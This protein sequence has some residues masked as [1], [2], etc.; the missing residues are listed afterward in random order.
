MRIIVISVILAASAALTGFSVLAYDL[1]TPG[2]DTVPLVIC[3][4]GLWLLFALAVLLLRGVRG[5]AV[6]VLILAGSAVIGAAAM[7]GP[8]NTSTDSARYAWDGVVA[9]AGVSPYAYTP[10][11][12]RLDPLRPGWL[13]PA[14][15][16]TDAGTPVCVGERIQTAHKTPSGD[17]LCS[18]LNRT[19]VPTIYP[20]AAEIYFA[21]VRALTGPDA[22]Y[23]PL[24]LTGLLLSVGTTGMLLAGMRRRG[25][26][27]RHAALWAWCPLVAT[28]AIT[29][30]HVDMLG[31][32]FT[33]A[34]AF[35]VSTRR[36]WGGGIALGAAIATK[37]IPVLA[38][39]AMLRRQGWKVTVAAM[40]TFLLLY[41]PYVLTT[42]IGVLG[43][44]PGYLSEEGYEDGTRFALISLVA[45][46]GSAIIVAGAVL[47]VIA[48]LV[49][50]KTDPDRPWLGQ[51]VMIGSALLILSPRYSWYAL[52]LVPFIALSGRWEW[53]AVPL[54]LTLRLLVPSLPVT[55]VA[56]AAAVVLIVAITMYR[57][58]PVVFQRRIRP[59]TRPPRPVA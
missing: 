26:D 55:R 57:A 37:L 40:L 39:P 47:A 46:G 43:Y 41:V 2:R 17:I 8:P 38:A 19:G 6:V 27:Q 21:G 20:P 13:F 31:V 52:L 4:A 49:I 44:L 18:A 35:L 42:G 54:A 10:A 11:D 53:F 30:S 5:R 9:T 22:Q 59:V 12:D 3:T 33:L 14:A 34:A 1:F 16:T 25:I 45:P 32:V 23:W 50:W 24:Q 36:Y 51:L 28:E 7:I 56:L 58:G 15:E 29:N 48:V